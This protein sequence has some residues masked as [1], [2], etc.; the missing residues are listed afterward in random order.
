MVVSYN[1]E[2]N[3]LISTLHGTQVLL[4]VK[5]FLSVPK[6]SPPVALDFMDKTFD[7]VEPAM[8]NPALS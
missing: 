4:I 6:V 5:N 7:V 3:T 1:S 2:V 8:S